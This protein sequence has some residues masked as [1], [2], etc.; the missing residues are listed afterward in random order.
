MDEEI[1]DKLYCTRAGKAMDKDR[2]RGS[3]TVLSTAH[4]NSLIPQKPM[5]VL[6]RRRGQKTIVPDPSPSDTG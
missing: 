6:P 1:L 4:Y 3:Q 2:R 5:V